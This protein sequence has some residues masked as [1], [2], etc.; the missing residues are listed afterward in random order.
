MFRNANSF[1]YIDELG[2]YYFY[3]HNDSIT[4]TRYEPKKAKQIIYSIFSNINFL[5]EKTENSYLSKYY[6]IF[7][8]KSG[9]QKYKSCFKY[10][11]NF[12]LVIKVLNKLLE[13]KYI[14]PKNKLIVKKIK[15]EIKLKY[16]TF[17]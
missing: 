13:S 7:K 8:L 6:C 9:F 14:S 3:N 17:N 11:K 2:Y 1:Q 5:Y 12:R 4:N 15:K 16:C 10:L